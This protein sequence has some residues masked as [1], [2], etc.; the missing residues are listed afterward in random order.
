MVLLKLATDNT[1]FAFLMVC[2]IV[3]F[4]P[5]ENARIRLNS[6]L[7]SFV[8]PIALPLQVAADQLKKTRQ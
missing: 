3:Y 7:S 6:T 1:L 5:V 2:A 8:N 4:A